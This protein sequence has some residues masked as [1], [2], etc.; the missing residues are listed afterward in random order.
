MDSPNTRKPSFPRLLSQTCEFLVNRAACIQSGITQGPHNIP[1][2]S[3]RPFIRQWALI[4]G[5]RNKAYSPLM[6]YFCSQMETCQAYSCAT[7]HHGTRRRNYRLILDFRIHKTGHNF[8]VMCYNRAHPNGGKE[9][10]SLT[11]HSRLFYQIGNQRSNEQI[12]YIVYTKY[13]ILF[14]LCLLPIEESLNAVHINHAGFPHTLCGTELVLVLPEWVRRSCAWR[15][16]Y[17]SHHN[18]GLI[19][20][21]SSSNLAAFSSTFPGRVKPAL[22]GYLSL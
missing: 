8:L 10:Y 11:K 12:E 16:T 21:G 15:C 4:Y 6:E 3:L 2:R 18:E 5:T 9:G 19:L 17:L 22:H 1:L 14:F 20:T 7:M 13:Y